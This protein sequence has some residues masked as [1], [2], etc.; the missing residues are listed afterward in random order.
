MTPQGLCGILAI[1]NCGR[2]AVKYIQLPIICTSE[3]E[4]STQKL[5]SEVGLPVLEFYGEASSLHE[6]YGAT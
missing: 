1:R 6:K 5:R 2:V 4:C 3:Y